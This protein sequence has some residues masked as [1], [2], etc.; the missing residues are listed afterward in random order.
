M[1]SPARCRCTAARWWFGRGDHVPA[2]YFLQPQGGVRSRSRIP[3]HH[4]PRPPCPLF[5]NPLHSVVELS[6]LTGREPVNSTGEL[7]PPAGT[8]SSLSIWPRGLPVLT[9]HIDALR[10]V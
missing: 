7:A 3:G 10:N 9:D 6:W 1:P 2:I 8:V 4:D 5:N